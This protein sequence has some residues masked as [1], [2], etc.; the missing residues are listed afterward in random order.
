M[1]EAF[2]WDPAP[3]YLL[4]DSDTIYGASFRLRVHRLNMREVLI[5]PPE[6]QSQR[7]S[8]RVLQQAAAVAIP[9]GSST[10]MFT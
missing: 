2:P 3:H 9:R 5:A 4:R 6:A 10:M 1:V 8:F 7:P